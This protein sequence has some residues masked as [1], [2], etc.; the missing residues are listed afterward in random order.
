MQV[1]KSLR[2]IANFSEY[3]SLYHIFATENYSE[4]ILVILW[5]DNILEKLKNIDSLWTDHTCEV[6]SEGPDPTQGTLLCFAFAL[7]S[8]KSD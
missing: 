2:F 7:V 3:D 4:A 8:C 5:V 6:M 1:C